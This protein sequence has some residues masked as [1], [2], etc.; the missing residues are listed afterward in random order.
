MCGHGVGPM[1][2]TTSVIR[3]LTPPR[4]ASIRR[5][6]CSCSP[7]SAACSTSPSAHSTQSSPS[8]RAPS[9]AGQARPRPS[10]RPLEPRAAD[11]E[12]AVDED[13]ELEARAG[14]A[15][16]QAHTSFGPVTALGQPDPGHLLQA[17]HAGE[18]LVPAPLPPPQGHHQPASSDRCATPAI[19]SAPR[20]SIRSSH[21]HLLAQQYQ[22]LMRPLARAKTAGQCAPL[23]ARPTAR[24]PDSWGAGAGC[25]VRGGR[26]RRPAQRKQGK[27]VDGT[28]G[29]KEAARWHIDSDRY[30][31]GAGR[32]G[33]ACHTGEMVPAGSSS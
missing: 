27:G 7:N 1:L 33:T 14:G 17:P 24:A 32:E 12:A 3:T 30:R 31:M 20:E 22:P 15:A 19:G 8:Q 16:Q 9:A 4:S 11:V 25:A 18:Q 26:D 6:S 10:P 29:S 23:P 5:R 2:V 21:A 28:P 13:L